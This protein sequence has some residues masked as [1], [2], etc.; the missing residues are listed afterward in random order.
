MLR[1]RQ[2]VEPP[3][4]PGECSIPALLEEGIANVKAIVS[5]NGT[6]LPGVSD[7]LRRVARPMP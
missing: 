2:S 1:P 5:I 4:T 7:A 6:D 3:E